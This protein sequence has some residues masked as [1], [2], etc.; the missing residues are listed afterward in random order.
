[1]LKTPQ[2][3]KVYSSSGVKGAEEAGSPSLAPTPRKEA[4][5]LASAYTRPFPLH[6]SVKGFELHIP[7][8]SEID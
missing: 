4:F 6:V 8:E 3:T 7:N 2:R 1:M 5:L